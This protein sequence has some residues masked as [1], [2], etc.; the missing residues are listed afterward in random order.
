MCRQPRGTAP[1]LLYVR[2]LFLELCSAGL[3]LRAHIF[4]F[5]DSPQ[6]PPTANCQ[7]PPTAANRQP[8]CNTA[9]VVLCRAHVLTMKQRASP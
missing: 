3:S 2:G 9:S 4:F 7:P 6:G 8:L 5:K 1:W